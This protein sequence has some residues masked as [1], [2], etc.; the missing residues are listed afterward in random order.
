MKKVTGCRDHMDKLLY[1]SKK[2]NEM[3]ITIKQE[4]TASV[5]FPG[6]KGIP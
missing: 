1:I 5:K 3:I 6:K 4:E 2:Y